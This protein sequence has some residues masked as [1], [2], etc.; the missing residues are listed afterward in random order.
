VVVKIDSTS[1]PLRA[2][3]SG[4]KPTAGKV[5]STP[6]L[7]RARTDTLVGLG[8]LAQVPLVATKQYADAGA[9]ALYWPTIAKEVAILAESQEAI[10]N[11]IDPLMKVG[12]YTGLVAAILPLIL[13][14]GV[15]H[16]RIQPGAMGTVPAS[17]LSAQIETALAQGELEALKTQVQAEKAA[18][19]LR[20]ELNESRRAMADAM[21][22]VQHEAT[23]D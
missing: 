13:Q 8:Q 7:T 3:P 18:Q 21:R 14:I 5:T 9:V 20:E 12:P 17:T 22:D 4:A 19:A 2:A 10:A 16:G 23:G 15:N 11:I 1:P 6:S